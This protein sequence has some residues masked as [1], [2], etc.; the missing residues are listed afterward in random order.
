MSGTLI[1]SLAGIL[2][3]VSDIISARKI[4]NLNE[5]LD[6]QNELMKAYR[7]RNEILSDIIVM[8]EKDIKD[9]KNQ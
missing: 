6:M 4:N 8:M 9:L 3:A 7:E 1:L 2:L 5:R